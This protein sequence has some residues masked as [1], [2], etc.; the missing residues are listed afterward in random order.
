MTM[1]TVYQMYTGNDYLKLFKCRRLCVKS[2]R[3]ARDLR[4]RLKLRRVSHGPPPGSLQQLLRLLSPTS[5][6]S[7]LWI[8]ISKVAPRN[9]DSGSI[10][11]QSLESQRTGCQHSK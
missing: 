4:E 6:G 7:T 9:P 1:L 2:L 10:S 11:R 8:L 5:E 3:A